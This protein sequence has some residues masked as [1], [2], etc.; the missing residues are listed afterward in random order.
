MARSASVCL[1]AAW[2]MCAGAL[3]PERSRCCVR[4][5]LQLAQR[6][7]HDRRLVVARQRHVRRDAALARAHRA[8]PALTL[9]RA[10]PRMLRCDPR[11][12]RSTL[13]A[14]ACHCPLTRLQEH[15]WTRATA[16]AAALSTTTE[17]HCA[18]M[19]AEGCRRWAAAARQAL[20]GAQSCAQLA[21]LRPLA[22]RGRA[23]HGIRRYQC[24]ARS[25]VSVLLSTTLRAYDSRCSQVLLPPVH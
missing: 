10:E 24:I 19:H 17:H 22:V 4:S 6:R 9:P 5:A 13:P 3:A 1:S 21:P 25:S 8:P 20:R 14:A 11:L 23:G 16:K 12:P 18:W 7:E 15:A 2:T